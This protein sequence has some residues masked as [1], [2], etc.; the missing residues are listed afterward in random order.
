MVK[1]KG[2]TLIELLVVIA[3]I[4]IL[5]AMLLPALSR[6]TEKAR[7]AACINNLKQIGLA[8]HMYAIDYDG[9]F[10][11][12]IRLTSNPTGHNTMRSLNLLTGQY[13]LDGSPPDPTPEREGPVYVKNAEVFV[14]PSM[15]NKDNVSHIGFLH[16]TLSEYGNIDVE[17][18][19]PT[20]SYAYAFP[21]S[22]KTSP[23]TVIMADRYSRQGNS[24]SNVVLVAG[25]NIGGWGWRLVTRADSHGIEGINV[26]YVGGNAKWV[27]TVGPTVHIYQSWY[28]RYLPLNEMPNC[29]WGSATT[30]RSP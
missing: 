11:T 13:D 2:F 8:L 18:M 30:L 16:W 10:P 24:G 28:G 15:G 6:A 22:V 4:A 29:F 23:D 21:L 20:C 19:K 14:C 7:R 5:A 3:I 27:P 25:T 9:F 17:K 12:N 1:K 26:L